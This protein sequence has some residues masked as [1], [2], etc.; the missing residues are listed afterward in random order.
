M[1]EASATPVPGDC[2]SAPAGTRRL[3]VIHNPIA[4]RRRR[5]RYA[6]YLEALRAR[7]LI[8]NDLPTSRR[9]DAE[10]WARTI[11]GA[12]GDMVVAAGGDGTINEVVNGLMTNRCG[13]HELPLAILPLGTAN[14][15]AAE[16]GLRRDVNSVADYIDRGLPESISLGRIGERYFIT[17]TGVGFDAHVVAEVDDSLKRGLGRLAYVVKLL[18]LLHAYDFPTYRA[19][20]AGKSYSAASLIIANGRFYG[21]RLLIAPSLSLGDDRLEVVL[22]Q[23]KGAWQALKYATALVLGLLPQLSDTQR[24]SARGLQVEGPPGDP[25]Q[26]DG[27]IVGRLPAEVAVVPHALRLVMPPR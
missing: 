26:A 12:E 22:F 5:Q 27:D 18:R 3:A 4:G 2:K 11:S 17:M 9:G 8:I 14:V 1:N 7:G 16:I 24:L 20:V 25:V 15:L 19:I 6:A 21:G 13:G 10:A 23:R